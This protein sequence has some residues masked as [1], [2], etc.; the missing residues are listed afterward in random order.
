MIQERE[1]HT[2]FEHIEDQHWSSTDIKDL[3]M[4]LQDKYHS[5]VEILDCMK[6]ASEMPGALDCLREEAKDRLDW[7]RRIAGACD[8][9]EPTIQTVHYGES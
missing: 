2:R 7:A 5:L 6:T 1:L 9:V 4:K 8:H 3:K